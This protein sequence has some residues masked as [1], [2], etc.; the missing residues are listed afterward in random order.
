MKFPY[1]HNMGAMFVQ[2]RTQ[3][4]FPIKTS[5]QSFLDLK[6]ERRQRPCAQGLYSLRVGSAIEFTLNW[7][8]LF[9]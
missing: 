7:D 3:A 5:I 1:K 8:Q 4:E 9:F 6:S 2:T